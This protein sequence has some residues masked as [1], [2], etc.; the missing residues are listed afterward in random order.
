MASDFA[1]QIEQLIK[2]FSDEPSSDNLEE[3]Y[4]KVSLALQ[5]SLL[6]SKNDN[7]FTK[8]LAAKT[9]VEKQ[10]MYASISP[11]TAEYFDA[12]AIVT[13][14][15]QED[16]LST[17]I[18]QIPS[19]EFISISDASNKIV[20]KFNCTMS[21]NEPGNSFTVNVTPKVSIRFC[22][23]SVIEIK[24]SNHPYFNGDVRVFNINPDSLC[25]KALLATL[26]YDLCNTLS[27]IK[28]QF[29]VSD[30][31]KFIGHKCTVCHTYSGTEK[32]VKCP[33]SLMLMHADCAQQYNGQFYSPHIA[34]KC[35][36][37]D[38]VS[39]SWIPDRENPKNIICGECVDE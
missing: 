21:S 31:T 2:E 39:V 7:V 11:R 22:P 18:K 10:K 28:Q 30:I 16:D 9:F 37:C 3:K 32:V 26:L 38:K 35:C 23:N 5:N 14:E 36:K 6:A 33:E 34:K 15:G 29:L 20:F 25:P 17:V 4:K 19:F 24:S 27:D 12:A 8:L 1:K 13:D